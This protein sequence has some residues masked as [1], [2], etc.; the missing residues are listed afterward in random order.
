MSLYVYIYIY[1]FLGIAYISP[2]IPDVRV[3]T[4]EFG[5]P[6]SIS[7]AVRVSACCMIYDFWPEK[8]L[9]HSC[10]PAPVF[11]APPCRSKK[12]V[13]ES[14]SKSEAKSVAESQPEAFKVVYS[15]HF[16]WKLHMSDDEAL[17]KGKKHTFNTL[18]K[19]PNATTF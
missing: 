5:S 2:P 12:S 6:S 11:V 7:N 8:Y 10:T 17:A 4:P 3:S 9:W 16:N 1:I 14:E 13:S 19:C 18:F 15:N